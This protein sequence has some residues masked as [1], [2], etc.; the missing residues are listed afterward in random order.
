MYTFIQ[1]FVL[2]TGYRF[3]EILKKI[4]AI[5][6]SL[7]HGLLRAKQNSVNS[8]LWRGLCRFISMVTS[9]YRKTEKETELW[10]NGEKWRCGVRRRGEGAGD[11][12]SWDIGLCQ[13]GGF[14]LSKFGYW[15]DVRVAPAPAD[16]PR[17]WL[18]L[19][20][21]CGDIGPGT[22]L[23]SPPPVVATSCHNTMAT[24]FSWQRKMYT[25]SSF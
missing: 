13:R 17:F 18:R 15:C 3:P 23:C 9:Q 7:R 5:S 2:V 10:G 1:M 25:F 11:K 12:V 16:W 14:M 4:F 20:P 6:H 8:I 21:G 22:S 19:W 24:I